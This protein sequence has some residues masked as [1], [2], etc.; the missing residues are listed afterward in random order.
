MRRFLRVLAPLTI[1]AGLAIPA[2]AHA[3]QSL[4]YTFVVDCANP[5][6]TNSL[7]GLPNGT[8]AVAAVGACA[9]NGSY[10]YTVGTPCSLPVVGT[11]PCVPSITTIN[12]FPGQLCTTSI[13]G[14]FVSL[15]CGPLPNAGLTGCANLFIEI[16]GVCLGGQAGLHFR[17]VGGGPMNVR[18]HDSLYT[19]NIG[20]FVVTVVWTPL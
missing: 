10:P 18:F 1:A 5:G 17:A 16:D 20:F 7:V 9:V 2:P 12:N 19:D 13:G 14:V 15:L 6:G 4:A 8:Y 11:I 3:L